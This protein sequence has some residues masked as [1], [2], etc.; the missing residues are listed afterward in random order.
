M[1][2]MMLVVVMT[3]ARL[4]GMMAV[5]IVVMTVVAVDKYVYTC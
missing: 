1:A 5:A 4:E 2:S 3:V